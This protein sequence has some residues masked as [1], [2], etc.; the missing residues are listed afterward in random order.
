MRFLYIVIVIIFIMTCNGPRPPPDGS[1][2]VG[3]GRA[4]PGGAPRLSRSRGHHS[5][6]PPLRM[7]SHFVTGFLIWDVMLDSFRYAGP[8]TAHPRHKIECS[9]TLGTHT[10]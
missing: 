8:A 4:W 5:S 9:R 1:G 6:V 10:E 3:V 7:R 2:W